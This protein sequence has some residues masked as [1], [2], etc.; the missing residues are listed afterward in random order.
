MKVILL[1]N[2]KNL[3]QKGELKN[4]AD[5]Y[6]RNFL[7]A[8]KL[9]IPADASHIKQKQAHDKKKNEEVLTKKAEAKEY[10][11]YVLEF[12]LKTGEHGETFG[13]VSKK[14]IEEALKSK[15]IPYESVELDK[16]IKGS[17]KHEVILSLGDGVKAKITAEIKAE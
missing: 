7:I 11:K 13:S 9:A 5:G 3:G 14:D 12:S 16:S 15:N 6:G 2:V 8:R 10:E 1:Q 4:V 17:G